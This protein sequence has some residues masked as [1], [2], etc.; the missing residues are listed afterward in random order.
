MKKKIYYNL[1]EEFFKR[2]F[3]KRR[4]NFKKDI[5]FSFPASKGQFTS[6]EF[7]KFK[8]IYAKSNIHGGEAILRRKTESILVEIKLRL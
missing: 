3:K 8:K 5:E 1:K 2:Y 7:S 4:F 6:N